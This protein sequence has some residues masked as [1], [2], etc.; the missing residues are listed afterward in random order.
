MRGA[1]YRGGLQAH[2]P[3]KGLVY[4]VNHFKY[5]IAVIAV[6]SGLLNAPLRAGDDAS[7]AVPTQSA[8][9]AQ[10]WLQGIGFGTGFGYD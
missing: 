9:M 8:G 3:P 4:M 7:Y 6:A 10:T 2:P 1:G 5:L